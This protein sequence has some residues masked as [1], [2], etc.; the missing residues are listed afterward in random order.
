L[1]ERWTPMSQDFVLDASLALSWCYKDEETEQ[2]LRILDLFA[3]G[4][5]AHVPAL[6][7]WEVNNNLSNAERAKRLTTADRIQKSSLL[8]ALPIQVDTNSQEMAWSSTFALSI[9]HGISVYAAAYLE[10]AQRLSLALGSFDKA[11]KAAAKR[12][13]VPLLIE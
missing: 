12:E 5:V 6:W 11:L 10:I 1:E 8:Q 4:A 2:S 7:H 3:D 9:K 13:L